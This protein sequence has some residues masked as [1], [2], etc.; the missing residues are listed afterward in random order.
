[1]SVKAEQTLQQAIDEST[2]EQV[3]VLAKNSTV[4]EDV[5]VPTGKAVDANGSTFTGAVTV[6]KDAVLQN[7]VFTGKVTVA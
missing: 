3:V 7:A 2:T 4:S 6:A 5:N 1:M